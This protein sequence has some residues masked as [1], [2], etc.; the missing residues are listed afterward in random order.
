MTEK[1]WRDELLEDLNKEGYIAIGSSGILTE[2]DIR[3]AMD[4]IRQNEI[5]RDE[6]KEWEHIKNL[7]RM[8]GALK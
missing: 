2:K 5:N 1:D 4:A 8:R 6:M 7:Q 3:V